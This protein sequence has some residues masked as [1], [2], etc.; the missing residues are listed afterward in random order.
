MA[1]AVYNNK[2]KPVLSL[3]T[4]LKHKCVLRNL[5]LFIPPTRPKSRG[6]CLQRWSPTRKKSNPLQEY[7]ESFQSSKGAITRVRRNETK[8]DG[9]YS[10]VLK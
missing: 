2:I 1:S 5:A 8:K 3:I 10:A 4:N 9:A 6:K 7:K